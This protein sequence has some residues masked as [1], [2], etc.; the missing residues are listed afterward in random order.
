MITVGVERPG[1]LTT[2]Q[3]GGRWG[4]QHLGV[5]VSGWMDSCAA[6]LAHSLLDNA[7]AAALFEVT[8][9]GPTLS[10]DG[11]LVIAVTGAEFSIRIGDRALTV[12]FVASVATGETIGFG[13]RL[14][15]ARAYMA[16]AGGVL[17]PPV[18]GSRATDVRAR[19]GGIH[20]RALRA[21]DRVPVGDTPAERLSRAPGLRCGWIAERRLRLLPPPDSEASLPGSY[22]VLCDATCT[23]TPRSDRMGYRMTCDRPLAVAKGHLLSQPTVAGMVQLPPDGN[24]IL[25]MADRQTTGGYAIAGVV[26][27]ADLPVAAQ[28]LPGDTFRFEACSWDAARLALA[29]RELEWRALAA[30]F[31][32]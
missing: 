31:M 1:L 32:T 30:E 26:A 8:W 24:P 5:P 18:L 21:G 15:G 4:T 10:A 25:L 13:E 12:P 17:V 22:D 27:Q 20:G 16:V 6:R 9:L 2:I 11:P 3:D 7:E 23:V 14:A 29:A 28:L 19:L